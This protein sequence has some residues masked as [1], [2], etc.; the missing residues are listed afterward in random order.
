MLCH[1]IVPH[2][3]LCASLTCTVGGRV[4]KLVPRLLTTNY[5]LYVQVLFSLVKNTAD[6]WISIINI[7]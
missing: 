1:A 7:T 5:I 6:Y 3:A 2:P 4:G